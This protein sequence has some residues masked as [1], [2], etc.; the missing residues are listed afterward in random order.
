[1]PNAIFKKEDDL[2]LVLPANSITGVIAYAEDEA[3]PS[4]KSLLFATI[5]GLTIYF[6]KD[7]AKEAFEKIQ[8]ASNETKEWFELEA[9]NDDATYLEPQAVLSVEEVKGPKG[10]MRL[11]VWYTRADGQQVFSDVSHSP[12]ALEAVM[13]R[14]TLNQG[15]TEATSEAS[16]KGRKKR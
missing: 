1:M 16:T 2:T 13:S 3:H 6:L 8:K 15:E 12:E 10:D 5:R 14:M 4:A 7:T 11:R 9:P